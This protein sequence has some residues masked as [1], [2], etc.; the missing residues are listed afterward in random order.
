MLVPLSSLA[1]IVVDFLVGFALLV[2]LL[3]VF[4][5]NPGWAVLLIP[6]WVLLL[7][8]LGMGIGLGA[9]AYMVKYRDVGYVLPWV[10]QVLMYASPLAYS[11]SSVPQNLLW[12]FYANPV[13]WFLEAF[14]WSTLGTTAPPS[15]QIIALCIAA[16]VVF[17]LGT[18]IFQKN[19][20]EFADYI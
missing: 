2:V 17:L 16:P 5:L 3:F 7:L 12:L 18:M 6:V 10:M 15:W 8:L 13:T 4:G 19:E 1:S 11:L 20:R 9:A 14:R